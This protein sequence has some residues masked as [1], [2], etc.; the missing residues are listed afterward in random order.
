MQVYNERFAEVYNKNW[1]NFA[2]SLAPK[3][4][5]FFQTK[6]NTKI[7]LNPVLLDLCCGTGQLSH[8][9]LTKGYQ[10][11]GVDLSPH[12]IKFAKNNNLKYIKNKT[13]FFSVQD[14][15]KF[16]IKKTVPFVVSLYDALNHLANL[17]ELYSC[18]KQ[19]AKALSSKGVFLFDLNT[20]KGL[21]RWNE[22][23]IEETDE[24][25]SITRGIYSEDM[26]KAY[27]KFSG[28]IK[29]KLNTYDKFNEV[30]Y[31]T[32]FPLNSV[33]ESLQKLNFHNIYFTTPDNFFEKVKDPEK[34]DRIFI[35]AEKR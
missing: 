11:Y 24:I 3:I 4:H 19:V 13:A 5:N 12:M 16:K 2:Q 22:I 26:G 17:D 7:N 33:K 8:F 27:I 10:V 18:F 14:V 30:V 23:E 34:L 20:K 25:T 15:K 6:L 21:Q 35:I 29:N 1:T 32:V 28:F 31:N 9:F